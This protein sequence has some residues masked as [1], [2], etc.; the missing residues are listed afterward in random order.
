MG[1]IL[2]LVLSKI[3][4]VGPVYSPSCLEGVFSA[5][6]RFREPSFLI[7]RAYAL[8][9][10]LSRRDARRTPPLAAANVPQAS[11]GY[12]TCGCARCSGLCAAARR[13]LGCP[14]PLPRPATPPSL[15]G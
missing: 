6:H 12:S 2:H 14:G 15:G 10:S 7:T 13:P 8:K 11:L 1:N 5:T 4:Q 9:G 3:G